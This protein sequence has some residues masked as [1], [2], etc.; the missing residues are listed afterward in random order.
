[1]PE[2]MTGH[3]R[4]IIGELYRAFVLLGAESDLLGTVGSWRDSLPDQDVLSGL[5]A[6]N[7]GRL[8]KIKACIEHYEVSCPRWD[9]SQDEDPRTSAEV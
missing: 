9:C 6:W 4:E 3:E 5:K 7:D 1:M 2:A 8:A